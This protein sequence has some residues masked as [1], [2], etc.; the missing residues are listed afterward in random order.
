ML[1]KITRKAACAVTPCLDPDFIPAIL[2]D[3]EFGKAV[4]SSGK[5]RK[6]VVALERTPESI[7]TSSSI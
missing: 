1:E 2:W 4:Q 3:R 5:A 6:I 7:S